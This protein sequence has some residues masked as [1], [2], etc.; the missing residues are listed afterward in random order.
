MSPIQRAWRGGKNDWRL[1]VLSIFSVAVAFVCL[2][3]ALLVVVN[4]HALQ[5]RW[6][7]A[8]R[9]SV[10][11]QASASPAQISIIEKALRGTPGVKNVRFVSSEAARAELTS[12][13]EDELLSALPA[14]AFPASLEVMISDDADSSRVD[15]LAANLAKL[16]AV[17]TVETY[18]SW[19]QKLSGLLS[20]GVSAA[21]LLAIVVLA[22]VVSVVGSTIRMALQR[23]SVEVEV[24]K[25]VGA[26]DAYVRRPYVI[27][28]A[29]QG[30]IG[31]FLAILLM[32]VL[33]LLVRRGVDSQ[34][35]VLLGVEPSFLPWQMVLSMVL[36]GGVLGALAAYGSLR[37]L[38]VV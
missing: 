9:A 36:L 18:Q 20:G 6:A 21:L 31:A 1:H 26:T 37:R 7:K 38:L 13:A 24:L 17:E 15:A 3:S 12:R 14:E 32:G 33:F 22:A 25:V 19:T 30:A 28:G 16:P 5:T 4:I 34:V 35:S 23:R 29:A 8:G 27:E 11:L 2:A 10:Y